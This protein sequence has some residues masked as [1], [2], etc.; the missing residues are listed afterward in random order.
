MHAITLAGEPR[1]IIPAFEPFYAWGRDLSYLVIRLTTGGC[2][3][4]TA[5]PS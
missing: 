2:C 1:L 4:S 3:L 5:L